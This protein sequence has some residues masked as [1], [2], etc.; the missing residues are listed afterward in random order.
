MKKLFESFKSRIMSNFFL[1]KAKEKN[2]EGL[3]ALHKTDAILAINKNKTIATGS[4]EIRKF[5]AELLI[6]DMKFEVG[7]QSPPMRR[8]NSALT[9]SKLV[10]GFVTA[11]VTRLQS[12]NSCLLIIDQSEIPVENET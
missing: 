10:N 4:E 6:K 11:E 1:E 5:Y 3:W 2:I 8:G 7:K 9:L 12:D